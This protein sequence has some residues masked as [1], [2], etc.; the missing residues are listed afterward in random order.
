MRVLVIGAG[1]AALA[2]D[3]AGGLVGRPG[4]LVGSPMREGVEH[5]SHRDKTTHERDRGSRQPLRGICRFASNPRQQRSCRV[6]RARSTRWPTHCETATSA[7][8]IK[9]PTFVTQKHSSI[10]CWSSV[11]QRFASEQ[12]Q[13]S[14]FH[15][16]PRVAAQVSEEIAQRTAVVSLG[17]SSVRFVSVAAAGG[18]GQSRSRGCLGDKG[19]LLSGPGVSGLRSEPGP[20]AALA[21]GAEVITVR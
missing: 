18:K 7:W 20:R 9:P 6:W 17:G 1:P 4:V 21:A 10:R 2:R 3:L 5:V 12:L 11:S 16:R 13:G 15:C 19:E 14:A 8:R